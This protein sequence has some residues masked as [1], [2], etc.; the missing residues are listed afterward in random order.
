MGKCA[1]GDYK[2]KKN[3]SEVEKWDELELRGVVG[4]RK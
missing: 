4:V 3:D 1:T 2:I